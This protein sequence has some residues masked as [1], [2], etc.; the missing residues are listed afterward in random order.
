MQFTLREFS[1]AAGQLVELTLEHRG[2]LEARVMGHN[3]VILDI[4]ESTGGFGAEVMQSGGTMANDYLPEDMQGRVVAF[5][6]MTSDDDSTMVG[7]VAPEMT[8]F[9]ARSLATTSR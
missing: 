7:S 3:V 1:V 5:T 9:S 4:G 6:A 8:L 2:R